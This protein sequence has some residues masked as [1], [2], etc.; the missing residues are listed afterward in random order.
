MAQ[1]I[2][3]SCES[4]RNAITGREMILAKAVEHKIKDFSD[5]ELDRVFSSVVAPRH[6]KREM[7]RMVAGGLTLADVY[8]GNPVIGDIIEK[9]KSLGFDCV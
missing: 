2:R 3:T 5:A 9:A 1:S 4:I 6:C 8:N 7:L